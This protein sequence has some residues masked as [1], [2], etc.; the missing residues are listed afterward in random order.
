M[1]NV[2]EIL[3]LNNVLENQRDLHLKTVFFIVWN[4][5]SYIAFQLHSFF[6]CV[7]KICLNAVRRIKWVWNLWEIYEC[8]ADS[9]T[10]IYI[11]F[12][13]RSNKWAEADEFYSSGNSSLVLSLLYQTQRLLLIMRMNGKILLFT[14]S[15]CKE[16]I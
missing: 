14:F 2:T 1:E 8:I 7:S 3:R 6:N 13:C 9:R 10:F 16:W 4:C 5:P 12:I 11:F 15:L